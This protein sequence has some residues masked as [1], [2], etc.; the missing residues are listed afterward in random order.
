MC[1][2]L[3][4]VSVLKKKKALSR[5]DTHNKTHLLLAPNRQ[6]Y[7][8]DLLSRQS[9]VTIT[10][11]CLTVF[12]PLY[13]NALDPQPVQNSHLQLICKIIVYSFP[14]SRCDTFVLDFLFLQE[15][16]FFCP[17]CFCPC[18]L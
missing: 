5:L 14:V 10:I 12:W 11:N 15:F 16:S 3:T 13:N 17:S 7:F 8:T 18:N 1:S 4:V 6:V 9:Y 2:V